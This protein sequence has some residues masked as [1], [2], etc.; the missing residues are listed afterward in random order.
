MSTGNRFTEAGGEALYVQICA[1]C[2]QAGGKGAVGAAAY[3]ALAGDARLASA[4]YPVTVMLYGLRGMPALGRMMSD[5]QVAE[6]VNYVR[7]HFDN[8]YGDAVA[9][10]DV[11]AAR[12]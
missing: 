10:E 4:S 7:T 12:P 2:H 3:P 11:K 9:P 5:A 8:H 1:A 6:V